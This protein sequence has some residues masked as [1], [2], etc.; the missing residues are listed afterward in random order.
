MLNY[1]K[2]NFVKTLIG[3]LVGAWL[4]CWYV[5]PIST[6]NL[7]I[8][9]ARYKAGLIKKSVDVNG[10]TNVYLEGG[11]VGAPVVMIHG[12]GGTKDNYIKFVPHLEKRNVIIPDLSGQ[13]DSERINDA[14]FDI[15]SQVER[16]HEFMQTIGV[17]RFHIIGNSMGGLIAGTYAIKYPSEVVSLGIF[18]GAGVQSTVPSELEKMYERGENPF[19]INKQEDVDRFVGMAYHKPPTLPY[20]FKAKAL[21]AAIANKALN[22]RIFESIVPDAFSL[23]PRLN[24]IK[25]PTFIV[26]GKQDQLLNVSMVAAYE[27]GL[28]NHRVVLLD[29]CGHAPMSEKPSETAAAYLDFLKSINSK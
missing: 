11:S 12:L 27:K 3:L 21:D 20:P 26:W 8:D 16:L 18:A 25:A 28:K 6:A 1:M 13:G 24:E 23:E 19:D 29:D 7:I 10:R 17:T 2:K 9:M 22:L 14:N 5:F 4:L 15:D